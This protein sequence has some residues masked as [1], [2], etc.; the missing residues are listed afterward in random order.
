VIDE[1]LLAYDRSNETFSSLW[2]LADH[3]HDYESAASSSE[4]APPP[5]KNPLAAAGFD[6]V[7]VHYLF[8]SAH[9][10]E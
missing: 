7:F 5:A 9:H 3:L 4:S 8:S 1:A 10:E 6:S 2:D